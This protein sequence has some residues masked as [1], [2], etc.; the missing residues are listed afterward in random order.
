MSISILWD[1][2]PVSTGILLQLKVHL[3]L[4]CNDMVNTSQLSDPSM[5]PPSHPFPWK[6]FIVEVSL[7]DVIFI[8]P[9]KPLR[10]R[11]FPNK[12]KT[13]SQTPTLMLWLDSPREGVPSCSFDREKSTFRVSWKW[14]LSAPSNQPLRTKQSSSLGWRE[15]FWGPK[16]ELESL[17]N[18]REGKPL[19]TRNRAKV[20]RKDQL[21][22]W[23]DAVL[24]GCTIASCMLWTDLGVEVMPV[25]QQASSSV[26]KINSCLCTQFFKYLGWGYSRGNLFLISYQGVYTV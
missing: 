14:A 24:C 15:C 25:D 17:N 21:S 12:N 2:F 13:R 26:K 5:Q 18:W 7:K 8:A 11:G 19:I 23:K 22:S 3:R 1:T 20:K 16:F 6:L 4:N 9:Q 10:E